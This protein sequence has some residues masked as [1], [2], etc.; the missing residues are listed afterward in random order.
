MITLVDGGPGA[1][2]TEALIGV[3]EDALARGVRPDR[4]AY[5]AFSRAAAREARSRAMAK[6]GLAEDDLPHFR[7]IH[8]HCY[9]ALGI[10]R[11]EVVSDAALAEFAEIVGEQGTWSARESSTVPADGL[12]GVFDYARATAKPLRDAWEEHGGDLDWFRLDRFARSYD[13]W[14]AGEGLLDFGD[15]LSRYV[16]RGAPLDVDVT[17]VDE[18]QDLSP[19]Q[20]A[21]VDRATAG[22]ELWI[23]GDEDQA[24]HRW[25]GADPGRLLAHG[26]ATVVLQA[27]HRLPKAVFA[28][29]AGILS[30]IEVRRDKPMGPH[31]DAPEGAVE[32]ASRVDEVDLSSGSWLLLAR[33][34]HQLKALAAAARAAGTHYSLSGV[35]AVDEKVVRA[36]RA[37]EALRAGKTVLGDDAARALAALGRDVDLDPSGEFDADDLDLPSP[38][39]LWHDALTAIP[40]DERE[41]YLACLRRGEK[42]VGPPR[43]RV[44]T[45]H[46][47]KGLEADKVLLVTALT[48]RVRRG[49]ALDPDAEA[50]VFYVGATRARRELFL[51]ASPDGRGFRI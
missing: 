20:W 43:V 14:K 6:F 35:D 26:G 39:P 32:W 30:R 38:L 10:R 23:G 9:R 48:P 44:E 1:G 4:V 7:T 24:I 2:K 8:S 41:F 25:A 51:V 18:V 27:S 15:M 28:V 45:I 47:A 50:R 49:L 40:L 12:L 29:A 16:E 19:L 22:V 21:V 33:T 34:R 5:W 11:D 42:L 37:W 31:P 36:I 17:I 13:A 46:G 3:V